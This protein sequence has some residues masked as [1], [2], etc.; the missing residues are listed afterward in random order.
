M[1]LST[2]TVFVSRDVYFHENTFP[3]VAS[4]HDFSVPFVSEVDASSSAINPFVTP[5]SIPHASI[6]PFLVL[7]PIILQ[8]LYPFLLTP[9]LLLSLWSPPILL[10]LP[11]LFLTFPL[12]TPPNQKVHQ[13]LQNSSILTG[14]CLQ[15]SCLTTLLCSFSCLRHSLCH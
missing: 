2:K 7:L 12:Q 11:L 1:N 5:V 9:F 3:F 13:S 6:D 8:F 4:I 15:F 10:I 14:L